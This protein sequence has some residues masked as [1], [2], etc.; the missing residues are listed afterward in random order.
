MAQGR[1]AEMVAAI[2]IVAPTKSAMMDGMI[3]WTF[4]KISW[5][6]LLTKRLRSP[7]DLMRR[8][9]AAMVEK[10]ERVCD[11]LTRHLLF[12]RAPWM[13]KHPDK[14]KSTEGK[15]PATSHGDRM[16]SP[17]ALLSKAG[18]GI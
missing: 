3:G 1:A 6:E 13:A 7:H 2:S 8:S 4:P 9:P 10:T 16:L 14:R 11:A 15:T 12:L 5:D 17:A 18:I